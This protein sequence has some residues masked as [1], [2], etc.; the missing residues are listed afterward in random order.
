[1]KIKKT[2]FIH[3]FQIKM[4][5]PPPPK[6][7]WTLVDLPKDHWVVEESYTQDASPAR[8]GENNLD[9]KGGSPLSMVGMLGPLKGGCR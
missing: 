6:K 9:A 7:P 5:F 3:P 2:Y 4:H 1:M 8:K